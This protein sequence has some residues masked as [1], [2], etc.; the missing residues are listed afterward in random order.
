MIFN[1]RLS[2]KDLKE[3]KNTKLDNLNI[4]FSNISYFANLLGAEKYTLI[5]IPITSLCQGHFLLNSLPSVNFSVSGKRDI[6]EGIQLRLPPEF[7]E[8]SEEYDVIINCDSLTEIGIDYA[9]EYMNQIAARAK[10]FL[11]INHE[12]N[13]FTIREL[14]M[15]FSEMNLIYRGRSWVRPGYVEEFYEIKN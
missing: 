5:D 9:R 13:E 12:G 8:S 4:P 6:N 10:Y 11:S 15:E 14:A 7:F 3:L 2:C 1:L